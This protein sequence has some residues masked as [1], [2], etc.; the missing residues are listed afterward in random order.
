MI[1]QLDLHG[2]RYDE[3]RRAVEGFV[4]QHQK[5]LP[6]NIICGNSNGMIKAV[7]QTLRD[8]GCEWTMLRYGIILVQGFRK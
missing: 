8:M 2:Y 1:V 4:Y 3:A 5:Q 7:E 6:V